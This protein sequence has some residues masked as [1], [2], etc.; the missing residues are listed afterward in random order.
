MNAA[1]KWLGYLRLLAMGALVIMM[2][3]TIVD[4]TMRLVLN[5]LVL[6]SVEI[7]QL[8]LVAVVFLAIPETF[9]RDEHIAVDLIDQALSSRALAG[10]RFCA[11]VVTTVFLCILAW[12][13]VLPA[14]DTIEIGDRTSDLQISLFW[15]WL[16]ILVGGIAAAGTMICVVALRHPRGTSTES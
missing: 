8:T 5:Q 10:L 14:F 1:A 15:Y 7:V 11:D 16:P 9:L 4:V 3:I 2:S 12:R 6:G 13:M